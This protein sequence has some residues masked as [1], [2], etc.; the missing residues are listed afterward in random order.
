MRR[1]ARHRDGAASSPAGP[2]SS[3]RRR[4]AAPEYMWL[5]LG[6]MGLR[7]GHVGLQPGH[8][9]LRPGHVGLQPGHAGLQVSLGGGTLVNATSSGISAGC[10]AA[11]FALR[12]SSLS[13]DSSPRIVVYAA[14]TSVNRSTASGE[15]GWRSGWSVSA[16][17]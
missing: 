4:R 6:R 2:P 12:R 3:G 7:P 1:A 14:P 16:S 13:T 11:A 10:P 9:G 15:S 8:M 17:W 5:Q